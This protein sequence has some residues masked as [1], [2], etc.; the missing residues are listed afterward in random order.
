MPKKADYQLK[1]DQSNTSDYI[2]EMYCK[3]DSVAALKL[4]FKQL[5]SL[6]F[7]IKDQQQ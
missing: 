6:I 4:V 2:L 3:Y 7:F 1:S 5:H